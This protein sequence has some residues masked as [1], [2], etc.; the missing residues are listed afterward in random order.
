MSKSGSGKDIV[1]LLTIYE[2]FID[3]VKPGLKGFEVEVSG[4]TQISTGEIAEIEKRVGGKVPEDLRTFWTSGFRNLAIY[5]GQ[6][7]QCAKTDF[8]DAGG[9]LGQINTAHEVSASVPPSPNDADGVE[10]DRLLRLGIP[11]QGEENYCL[12]DADPDE[13]SGVRR[14]GNDPPPEEEKLVPI[15]PT[16]TEWFEQFLATGCYNHGNANKAHFQAYW[17]AI[18]S[19]VPVDIPARENKWLQFLTTWYEGENLN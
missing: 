17:K 3:A 13:L 8:L 5:D 6:S 1:Q 4:K 15:A 10:I 14:M 12:V 16:F 18:S 11:L 9:V 7:Y 2:K 19:H